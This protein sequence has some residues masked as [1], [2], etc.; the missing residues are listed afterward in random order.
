MSVVRMRGMLGLS[1]IELMFVVAILA[2]LGTVAAPGMMGFVTARRVEDVARQLNDAIAQGRIEAVKRNTAMLLCADAGVTNSTCDA[3]P[4]AGDW[5][6]GW[7]LCYD[8][9]S[10]G[11]CDTGT[12]GNPNPVRLRTAVDPAVRLSGPASR[13]RFNPNG[14]MTAGSFAVFEAAAVN[15]ASPRWTVRFAASGAF[16]VRRT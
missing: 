1:L 12:E 7:R 3:A 10:D 6:K 9:D 11:A 16:S 4:A 14:S 13:L 2:I 8:A 5:A 15:A